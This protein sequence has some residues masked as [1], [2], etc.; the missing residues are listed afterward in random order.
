MNEVFVYVEGP[1]D[2]LGMRELLADIIEHGTQNSKKYSGS[3]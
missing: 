3:K 1:S 2:Q